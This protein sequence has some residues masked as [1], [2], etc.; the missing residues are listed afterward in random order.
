MA[1]EECF[2]GCVDEFG[3]EVLE[4]V[5]GLDA[6]DLG[7]E[8]VDEAEVA[9]GDADDGCYGGGVGDSVICRVLGG[10]KYVGEDGGEFVG[11][12]R[13]VFVGEAYAA[14]ELGVAGES[15]E[16]IDK[17]RRSVIARCHG[18]ERCRLGL[19]GFRDS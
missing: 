7:E 6:G 3:C 18:K 10:G 2:S 1:D 5:E 4:F 11:C 16:F 12:Q 17:W 15:V 13:S 9:A 14:V 8:P 19:H